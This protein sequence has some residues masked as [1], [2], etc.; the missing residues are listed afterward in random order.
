MLRHGS[1]TS[2]GRGLRG[3]QTDS[4]LDHISETS[5][6]FYREFAEGIPDFRTVRACLKILSDRSL[7]VHGEGTWPTSW[8][9]KGQFKTWANGALKRW[10]DEMTPRKKEKEKKILDE[11]QKATLTTGSPKR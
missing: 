6:D 5:L 10:I 11:E 2:I 4:F 3:R 8:T 1:P 7:T 9:K